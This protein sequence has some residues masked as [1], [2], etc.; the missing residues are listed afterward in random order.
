STWII[1][2]VADVFGARLNE[3]W[4]KGGFSVDKYALNY[5][6]PP[7]YKQVEWS[8]PV[9]YKSL[10]WTHPVEETKALM[11]LIDEWKPTH[12]YS[13]HNSGFTGTYYYITRTLEKEKMDILKSM[14]RRLRVP[15]HRGEPETPYMKKLDEA[16]FKMPSIAEYYDWLEKHLDKDPASIIEHGGSS[17]DYAVRINPEVFELVCEVPYI[18]DYKLGVELPIGIPRR[19]ILEIAINRRE[20][21]IE[22]IEGAMRKVDSYMSSDNPFYEA[23][24][25]FIRVER[26]N[27]VAMKSWAEKE[28]ELGE[29][30]TVAQAFNSYLNTI[31]SS[32]LRWGL[33]W[34]S[35]DY[36]EGKRG[37]LE[38]LGDVKQKARDMISREIFELNKISEYYIIP[39]RNT[40]S[41]QI[42]AIIATLI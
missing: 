12:I 20:T 9:S 6:R 10:N 16:I 29:S 3:G 40:V 23:L 26:N 37:A 11:K 28:S 35:I 33:L 21:S 41:I 2:K 25:Y 39:I 36:E 31:W 15:L 5:Y 30:A 22:D 14:P 4:F 24:T 19:D 18:Y 32:I 13:L 8:F 42:S 34:R 7:G 17:Y 1:V 38:S 27:I